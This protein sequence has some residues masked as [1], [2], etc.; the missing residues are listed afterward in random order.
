MSEERTIRWIWLKAMYIWTIVIACGFGLGI[1][2]AQEAV[3]SM[4]GESCDPMPYGM[5]GSVFL[6]FGLLAILGLRAPLRFVPILLL[7]LAYKV[8]WFVGVVLPF[9][10]T[11]RGKP[12]IVTVIIFALTI[13][14]DLIAIP[15][16]YVFAKRSID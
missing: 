6:A 3:K 12:D 13:V 1:I 14:G 15:F 7:Q 10:I 11:G 9:L 16:P 8:V 5:L 2:F 4:F